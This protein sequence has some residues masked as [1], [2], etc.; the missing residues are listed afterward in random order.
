MVECFKIYITLIIRSVGIPDT[1]PFLLGAYQQEDILQYCSSFH[2]H[3]LEVALGSNNLK[4]S[5]LYIS[6]DFSNRA[7]T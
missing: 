6:Y 4:S 2:E 1:S 5:F 3:W 7:S